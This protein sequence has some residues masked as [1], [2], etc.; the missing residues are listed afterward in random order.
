MMDKE[1]SPAPLNDKDLDVLFAAAQRDAPQL[2]PEFLTRLQAQAAAALPRSETPQPW[3]RA[4]FRFLSQLAAQFGGW[5]A[6]AGL[7]MAG[8]TGVVIG[9]SPPDAV[10]DIT[11][12]YFQT[13]SLSELSGIGLEAEFIWEDS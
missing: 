10:L 9:V 11:S 12:A 6:G 2:D 5:P 3:R 4:V 1:F 7:A 13:E 8:A